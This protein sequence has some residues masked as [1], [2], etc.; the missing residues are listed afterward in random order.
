MYREFYRTN[1]ELRQNFSDNFVDYWRH[2]CGK[3]PYHISEE[4]DVIELEIH[5]EHHVKNY[6]AG[7]DRSLHKVMRVVRE[8]LDH[9]EGDFIPF[10]LLEFIY[11]EMI[12]F[13]LYELYPKFQCVHWNTCNEIQWKRV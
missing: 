11:D 3:E 10:M 4:K 5:F 9:D 6:M 2:K 12:Q 13:E 7:K 1:P 8:F